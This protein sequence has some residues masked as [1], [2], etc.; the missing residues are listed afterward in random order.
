[1]KAYPSLSRLLPGG[2]LE[3][4]HPPSGWDLHRFRDHAVQLA[5]EDALD[6]LQALHRELPTLSEQDAQHRR[7]SVLALLR[8][9]SPG[10]AT[11]LR[12]VQAPNGQICTEPSRMAQVLADHWRGVFGPRRARQETLRSWLM[13]DI[14]PEALSSLPPP[15][16]AAWKL[17]RKDVQRAVE[18]SP[19]SSPG[20][21]GILFL[22]WRKLG[23]LAISTLF[24]FYAA[25]TGSED[26]AVQ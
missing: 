19:N 2:Q 26:A 16:A 6:R 22:A 11:T 21:D 3:V 17:T 14:P 9:V 18:R 8:R 10:R 24:N 5:R 7:N 20:P 25:L 23:P 15:E 4:D 13:E 12:A 1:M